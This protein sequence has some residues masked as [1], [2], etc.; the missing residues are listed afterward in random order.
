[1]RVGELVALKRGDLQSRARSA[2]V[3]GKGDK[4][5][6][7][8]FAPETWTAIQQYLAERKDGGE[9]RLLADLPLFAA[10]DR[11]SAKTMHSLTTQSVER[12]F[13]ELCQAA[14]L[15]VIV[16]PHRLRATF[17]TRML[18]AT[19]NLALVQDMLGHDSPLTTRRYAKVADKKIRDAHHQVFGDE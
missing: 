1:M 18:D 5:R 7:V 11:S 12:R 14:N 4:E 6:T 19:D 16:T 3:T 17:A 15:G 10:H 2:R 13:A 8:Y 9:P